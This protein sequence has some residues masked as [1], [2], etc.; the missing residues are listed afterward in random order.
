[1]TLEGI[2]HDFRGRGM[3]EIESLGAAT[4]LEPE[5]GRAGTGDVILV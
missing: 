2:S 5:V 3:H 1:M 4:E